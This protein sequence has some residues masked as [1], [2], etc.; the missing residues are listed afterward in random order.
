MGKIFQSK[1][2]DQVSP[3]TVK[4]FHSGVLPLA[5]RNIYISCVGN[6]TF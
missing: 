4:R 6:L 1:L 2:A 3:T 5:C